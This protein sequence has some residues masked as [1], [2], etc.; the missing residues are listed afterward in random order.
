MPAPNVLLI[1]PSPRSAPI[2]QRALQS[3]GYQV[4]RASNGKLGM[5]QA[6]RDLPE[7]IILDLDLP[8]VDSVELIRRLRRDRRTADK[9]IL[10]MILPDRPQRRAEATQAG[11]TGCVLKQADAA[12]H[13]ILL[14]RGERP[15]TGPLLRP[16]TR[17]LGGVRIAVVCPDAGVGCTTLC[18]NLASE[19]A[20]HASDRG[21]VAV[22]LAP[23]PG[24]FA[25]VTGLTPEAHLAR[26]A[27][28]PE[29]QLGPEPLRSS[30]QY[31]R[32][33][34]FH[35]VPA[36]P[37]LRDTADL[38]PQWLTPLLRALERA[39]AFVVL[40]IGRNLSST[41]LSAAREAGLVIVL[42]APDSESV[43]KSQSLL[44]FLQLEDVQPERM[45]LVSNAARTLPALAPEAIEQVL[46]RGPDASLPDAGPT[47][48]QSCDE[49]LPFSRRFPDSP[50]G[51]AM[52]DLG[53]R[54]TQRVRVSR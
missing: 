2:L 5:I 18:L 42:F 11:M 52:H 45:L 50:W 41:N 48:R 26:L 43:E 34:G 27:R 23:P 20:F 49:H 35:S 46:G 4:Q 15:I 44:R 47:L 30:I 6:W 36:A 9:P 38:N 13:L 32:I 21:C 39:F 31:A 17:P 29:S 1:D 22:D 14:L 28:L 12:E 40:D 53:A 8:D 51:A 25:W 16:T 37:D 3:A 24:A 19:L 7:A 33:W 10:G 54:L